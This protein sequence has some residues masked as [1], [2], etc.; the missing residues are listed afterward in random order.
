[1]DTLTTDRLV[2]CPLVGQDVDDLARL[3]AQPALMQ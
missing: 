2:L 3:L 1:M